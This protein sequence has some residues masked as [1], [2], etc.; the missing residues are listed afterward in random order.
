MSVGVEVSYLVHFNTLWQNV[1]D[2][3]TKCDSYF[4]TVTSYTSGFLSQNTSI[5]LQ[6]TG[7][8]TKCNDFITKYDVYLVS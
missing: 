3:T 4:N 6:N 8:I 1:T 7:V 5:L 2:T